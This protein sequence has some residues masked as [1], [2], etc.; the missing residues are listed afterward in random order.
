MSND[1]RQ[2]IAARPERRKQPRKSTLWHGRLTTP[3]GTHDCRVLDFSPSGAK[4]ELAALAAA[5]EPVTLTLD[6]LG[7]FAGV[8]AWRQERCIGIAIHEHRFP[9]TRSRMVLPGAL[10]VP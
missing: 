10:R 3:T 9:T 2:A 5:A 1:K 4:I 7:I 6:P 8:V